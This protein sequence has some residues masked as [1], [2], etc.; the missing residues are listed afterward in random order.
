MVLCICDELTVTQKGMKHWHELYGLVFKT[1]L[2]HIK[3]AKHKVHILYLC[4]MYRRGKLIN[5]ESTLVVA[6]ASGF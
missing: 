3:E 6:T 1:L 4:E 5:I 2:W